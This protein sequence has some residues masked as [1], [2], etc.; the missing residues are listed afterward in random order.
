M[1]QRLCKICF[2]SFYQYNT[3]QTM[4]QKCTYNKYAKPKKPIKVLG[5]K[6]KEWNAERRQ[7][8]KDNPGINGYWNCYLRATPLCP[9]RLDI[10]QLTLDHTNNRNNK[11]TLLP[12]CIYCNGWKGSRSLESVA[13]ELPHVRKYLP[14]DNS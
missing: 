14:V 2:T 4:C 11:G 7:W 5:K 12:A 9:G 6:A 3:T 1:I 10:D 13:K 8:I